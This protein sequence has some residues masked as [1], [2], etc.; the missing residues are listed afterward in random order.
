MI[1]NDWILKIK[2]RKYNHKWRAYNGIYTNYICLKCE[3]KSEFAWESAN[4][5]SDE[6]AIIKKLVE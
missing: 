3:L 4:C 2:S 1:L 5:I 6:E